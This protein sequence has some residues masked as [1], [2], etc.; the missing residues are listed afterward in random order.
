MALI[1]DTPTRGHIAS[2]I[3]SFD[4][5]PTFTRFLE[6][7]FQDADECSVRTVF[8]LC[9]DNVLEDERYISFMARFG[10]DVQVGLETC[11]TFS[12]N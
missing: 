5:S 9:G 11:L 1:L 8:H 2:L 3:N 6:P 12:S 10:S 4:E 7:V